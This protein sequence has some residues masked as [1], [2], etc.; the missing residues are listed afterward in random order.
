V[1]PVER[2]RDLQLGQIAHR[3][4]HLR[5]VGAAVEVARHDA[6]QHLQAQ[7]PQP[8]LERALVVGL[9]ALQRRR[10]L[11]AR[12]GR[13]RAQLR[14]ELRARRERALGEAREGDLAVECGHL[15]VE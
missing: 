14:G 1:R 7:A 13:R 11:R 4:A 3:A 8:A 6:Q 5:Q 12:I 9:G 15:R 2:R 10:H